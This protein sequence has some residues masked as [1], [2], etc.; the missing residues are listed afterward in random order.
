MTESPLSPYQ[1]TAARFAIDHPGCGLFLDMGLGKTLTTIAVMDT[2][3]AHGERLHWLVVAPARVARDSW[4][5][6][7]DKWATIHRLDWRLLDGTPAQRRAMLDQ[8]TPDVTIV[9]RELLGW[10]DRTVKD[11]PWDALILDELSGYRNPRATRWRILK[12]HRKAMRRVIGL[13]G[14]PVPKS[15]DNLWAQIWLLDQGKSLGTSRTVYRRRWF[16]EGDRNWATGQVYSWEPNPG[17]FDEIMTAIEPFCLTMLKKDKLQGLPARTLDVRTVDPGDEAKRIYRTLT[18]ET[19]IDFDPGQITSANAG[20]LTGRLSQVAAGFLYPDRE[21]FRPSLYA[22]IGD[23]PADWDGLDRTDPDI[24]PLV[25]DENAIPVAL[26]FANPDAAPTLP[27]DA[28]PAGVVV[29]A[30]MSDG[31]VRRAGRGWADVRLFDD[32]TL[33]IRP[34]ARL[35]RAATRIIDS[36]KLDA[37]ADLVD[38]LDGQPL[39]VFH[40]FRIE[41]ERI[42]E[43]LG[44]IVHT[45]DEPDA[46]A[47]WNAGEFPVLACQPAGTQYGLNLQRGGHVI[48]WMEP[49][50]NLE[51]W[52]QANA[53]LDRRGQTHPVHIVVLTAR[54]TVDVRQMDVLEGRA[55]LADAV[56]AA[57]KE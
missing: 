47:R 31:T 21:P 56:A 54:D 32:G 9:S 41:L 33:T 52:S 7:L 13:T 27:P 57:L 10:L 24:P 1:K 4:P 36:A 40:R 22:A 39:L 6:E 51:E 19:A 48:C 16:H 44:P 5:D 18:R 53:R 35:H 46:V 30:D 49:T 15:L 45:L 14:T 3:K 25:G 38:A 42:R 37:L 29:L 8:P 43:R 26:R 20:V 17:A 28:N 23:G 12:T 50:W 2:L 55:K 11:W 34:T